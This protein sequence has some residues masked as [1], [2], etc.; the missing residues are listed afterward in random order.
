MSDNDKTVVRM[1]GAGIGYGGFLQIAVWLGDHLPAGLREKV[2][3][4]RHAQRRCEHAVT[5]GDVPVVGDRP[6]ALEKGTVK[7]AKGV[8]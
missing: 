2:G 1:A 8:E 6:I 3:V 4:Q 7:P 5:V